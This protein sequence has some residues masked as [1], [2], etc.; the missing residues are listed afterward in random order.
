[1]KFDAIISLELGVQVV[2][3]LK[4]YYRKLKEG[5]AVSVGYS[6]EVGVNLPNSDGRGSSQDCLRES[7]ELWEGPSWPPPCSVG[8][9]LAPL[10]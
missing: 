10:S 6:L 4:G 1:M 7:W 9:T 5:G 3:V 8:K 2:K